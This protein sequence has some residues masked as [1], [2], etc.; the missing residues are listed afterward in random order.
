MG[1]CQIP[2]KFHPMKNQARETP[3]SSRVS[4]EEGGS[5]AKPFDLLAAEFQKN[6]QAKRLFR[7]RVKIALV[8]GDL[9]ILLA[10]IYGWSLGYIPERLATSTA[11]LLAMAVIPIYF[12]VAYNQRAYRIADNTRPGV[13][14]F[15]ALSGLLAS[16]G[17]V[18]LMIFLTKTTDISRVVTVASTATSAIGICTFRAYVSYIV[19]RNLPSGQFSTLCIYDGL[20]LKRAT[21]ATQIDAQAYGLSANASDP[22]MIAKLAQITKDFDHLLVHCPPNKRQK[23]ISVMRSLSI[24]S[25]I[26]LPE[27]NDINPIG[28]RIRNAGV[29]GIIT[30]GPLQLHE[31]LLKRA[32]DLTIVVLALPFLL[33]LIFV[34]GIAIKLDSKGPVLFFQDRIGRDNRPFRIIKLRTMRVEQSDAHG[35]QSTQRDDPRTTKLGE[36]LRRTSLDE[37]PQLLNVLLGDMSLVGP[38]PHAKLSRAGERLFWE[39]DSAYWQ[40]HSVKP[41]ITGLAQ[42]RGHRGNTFRE[43]HLRARLGADLEY[44]ANWSLLNDIKII[45]RTFRVLAHDNAF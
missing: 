19:G 10:S 44:V 23:W 11:G 3:S 39:V 17:G 34:I 38:R 7:S 30:G 37:I 32:F 40:R 28:L 16:V 21:H 9:T 35:A 33:V 31:R 6:A 43:E 18:V 12:F 13:P 1:V 42:V 15:A 8:A 2:G 4:T 20:P 14:I 29:S 5:V 24:P 45:L 26:L 36:F 22:E 27:L 25:E 41:G